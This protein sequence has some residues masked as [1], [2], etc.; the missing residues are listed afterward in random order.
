MSPQPI[1][2]D[3][4]AGLRDRRTSHRFPLHLSVKYR[5][6]GNPERTEWV[7]SESVNI[8]SAGILFK[9][10][11]AV[12]PGQSLEALIAWP[13]F[14]DKRIPLKLVIRGLVVRNTENGS[15]MRFETYEFR[16]CLPAETKTTTALSA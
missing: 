10:P 5:P 3:R 6:F 9:T 11:E 14:L 4:K 7:P 13:V 12:P 1:F 15:A 2:G 8:S 16:T